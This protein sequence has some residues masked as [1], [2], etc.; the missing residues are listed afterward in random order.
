MT[1]GYWNAGAK[2][3]YEMAKSIYPYGEVNIIR[4]E[5]E[6]FTEK[7]AGIYSQRFEKS[8]NIYTTAGLGIE[9]IKNYKSGKE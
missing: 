3:N 7:G 2:V 9:G 1:A 6:N 4:Y 8:K 5:N